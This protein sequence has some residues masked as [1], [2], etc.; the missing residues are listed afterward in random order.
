MGY[1]LII[2]GGTV[3]DGTGAPAQVADIAIADGRIAKVGDLQGA[4]A[5]RVI[6]ARG[7]IV[8]PG[9]IDLHTHYDAPMHWDPYATSSSWHGTTSVVAGNCGFGYAPCRPEH[10][11][12]YMWMMVNT[13][14][15][16]YAAQKAALNWEWESFPQWM[17][18]LRRMPKGIN[19]A[20]YLPMNPLLIYVKGDEVKSRPTTAAERQRMREL[21]HEAMDAGA[22]GFSFSLLGNGN[23]HVDYDGT[24]VPTDIMDPEDAYCLAE[25]LRDRGEG[26]IQALTQLRMESR[27]EISEKLARISGRPI[28]HNALIVYDT[29]DNPSEAELRLAGQWKDTLAWADRL[30]AEGLDIYVQSVSF[31]GWAE[32]KIE[33]MTLF[34]AVPVFEEFSRCKTTEERMRL[35]QDP[36]WRRRA[37][38]GYRYE[39]FMPTGGGFQKYILSDAHGDPTYSKYVGQTVG[40][41]AEALGHNLV[42]TFFEILVATRM[43]VDFK[44]AEAQSRDGAKLEK[45]LRHPRVIPG[46]SDG[47]AHV[48]SFVGGHYSTDI[49]N[50]MVKEERRM[51][52]E[53]A[54]NALSH[55]PA[56]IFGLKDRGALLEGYAADIMIYDLDKLGFERTYVVANDLPGGDWRRTVP[57]LG[58]THVLVNGEV[59]VEGGQTTGALPGRILVSG[60]A[61]E[62][63]RTPTLTV[64]AE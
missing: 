44:L 18:H 34:N 9:V 37:R 8:A 61:G 57:A 64:A 35:A 36:E 12:Q 56:R 45:V 29:S 1:E 47:G 54:H 21:L 62:A 49:L 24:P 6:D 60:R 42:D 22:S 40:Q 30:V 4:E 14:Q 26:V 31:R 43:Q 28:I 32:L 55:R 39:Y 63:V 58:V 38:E 3:V 41:I 13:E 59:I 7:L 46:T 25:V 23:G 48:K 5:G 20:M 19:M 27:P 10:R 17:D 53:E 15:V 51:T 16:P 2:R 33:E 11:D 50:W 52:L